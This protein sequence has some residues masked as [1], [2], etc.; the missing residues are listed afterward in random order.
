MVR[1]KRGRYES[2]GSSDIGRSQEIYSRL[3]KNRIIFLSEDVT[4]EVGCALSALLIHYDHENDKEEIKIFINSNGGD[5]TAL[6]HMYDV[7]QMIRAPIST[8]CI[9]KAYSAGA[10]LLAAGTAGRRF[11]TKH[12]DIMIHGLQALFP[13]SENA[14]RID[15]EIDLDMLES[16]NELVMKILSRHTGRDY[17]TVAEDCKRDFYMDANQ[18][19]EYGMID[20][21]L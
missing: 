19:L 5:A 2:E 6:S 12:C 13:Q 10:V 17:A 9:G 15:T 18:A 7:M 11:G 3:A 4:K 14:D 1:P 20:H 21:I 8:Y 16:H